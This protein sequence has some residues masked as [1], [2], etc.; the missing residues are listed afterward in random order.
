[1]EISVL[2]VRS[3]HRRS[4]ATVASMN[5]RKPP[6]VSAM[7][8]EISASIKAGSVYMFADEADTLARQCV[9]AIR[10]KWP[11]IFRMQPKSMKDK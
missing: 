10:E 1:M 11:E 4:G 8:A 9:A 5:K 2:L 6:T 3:I 7:T